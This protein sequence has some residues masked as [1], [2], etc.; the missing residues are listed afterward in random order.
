MSHGGAQETIT[1]FDR[2]KLSGRKVVNEIKNIEF[3]Y[4]DDLLSGI[5]EFHK[6]LNNKLTELKVISKVRVIDNIYLPKRIVRAIELK[7]DIDR[8]VRKGH[9]TIEELKQARKLIQSLAR[10]HKRE[11][12]LK[13]M[14]R[15]IKFLKKNDSRNSWRFIKTCANRTKS[16]L[17]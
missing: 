17:I 10:K 6:T 16:N 3:N 5:T 13:Y 11:R 14:G 8:S 15:G 1:K 7:R 2:K 9:K 4:E 12:Y